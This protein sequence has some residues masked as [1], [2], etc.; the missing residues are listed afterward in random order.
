M[1][2]TMANKIKAE[3]DKQ[4]EAVL[5]SHKTKIR[6]VGTGGGGNNTVTRLVEV[7]ISEVDIIA[8]NTDAQDL[9]YAKADHKVLIGKNITNGLGAGS[10]PQKGE[11]SAKENIE[12]LEEVLSDS[13]MVFITCGLGGGTGT[14]SAPVIA[15]ISK[16]CGALTI[17]VVTLP[18]SDEGVIRWENARKGL[19]QLQNNVD[20][21]IVVQNDLLL[22]LVPDMPLNAA[23]KFADEILVNA[24][25]GITELVTEKGLVNLDFAD[26]K[27]IMQGGGLAMIGLGE[28]DS[29]ENIEEAAKKALENPLLDIDITGA[30]SALINIT[31]GQDMS[32]KS[33]KTIMKTVAEQ[34]DPSAKIIWGT[35]I[36]ES[37]GQSLRVMLIVTCLK[38]G[39]PSTSGKETRPSFEISDETSS[40]DEAE[41]VQVVENS[42]TA[43][44]HPSKSQK[45]FSEIFMEETETDISVLEEAINNLAVESGENEKHLSDISTSASSIYSSSELF[46]YDKISEFAE[47]LG[48]VTKDALNGKLNLSEDVI[49][50]FQQ[51][52]SALRSA[53][54]GDGKDLEEIKQSILKLLDSIIQ[55]RDTDSAPDF[56]STDEEPEILNESE[57]QEE[58]VEDLEHT[59]VRETVKYFDKLL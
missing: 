45:V 15:E 9:L 42:D 19:E 7:G 4:L 22:D 36:D 27:T 17:A 16:R 55:S 11:D 18:F 3:I 25:K 31:G 26:V 46:D 1:V 12:E 13:D 40:Q 48:E 5:S 21:V 28:T 50:L 33:A 41:E 47:L 6:I 43:S 39:Q 2:S 8:V 24:V 52:P 58:E 35:R 23:F 32:L 14:G 44:Q 53:T 49:E 51:M 59:N 34:L 54:K 29:Q 56:E 30:K 38:S 37:M 10:D 20:T 57:A